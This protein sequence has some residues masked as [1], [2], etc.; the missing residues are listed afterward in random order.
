[1]NILGLAMGS[2]AEVGGSCSQGDGPDLF[3]DA[4]QVKAAD[5]E[6]FCSPYFLQDDIV[7]T[8]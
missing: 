2:L 5:L 8:T 6:M 1:M 7:S 4:Q 3:V